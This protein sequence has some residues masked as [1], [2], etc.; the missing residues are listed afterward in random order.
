MII[1]SGWGILVLVIGFASFLLTQV[2][3]D[4]MMQDDQYYRTHGWPK[5]VGFVVA[6]VLTWLLGH[7]LNR[8]RP[9]RD[10]LFFIP[11]QFW[12]VIFLVLGIVFLFV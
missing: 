5:L 9:G 11:V 6:A 3:V 7:T 8:T 1:W 2:G 10:S 12:A 4:S